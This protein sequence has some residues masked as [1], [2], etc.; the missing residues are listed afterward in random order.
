MEAS[1]TAKVN[2]RRGMLIVHP[3][4]NLHV[5][6][7]HEPTSVWNI[8]LGSDFD[9]PWACY[10]GRAI[11]R[12]IAK[13]NPPPAHSV[14][15]ALETATSVD[16]ERMPHWIDELVQSGFDRFD[17]AQSILSREHAHRTF[18]DYFQM[19]PGRWRRERQIQHAMTLI[20]SGLDL[21]SVAYDAGFT[22]QSHMTKRFRKALGVTPGDFLNLTKPDKPRT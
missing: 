18:R 2:V 11:E 6:H 21:A 7:I 20:E 10:T 5:D 3:H 1:L 4:L 12:L 22:D 17:G 13:D 14:L 15:D 19:T 16:P 8:G 9:L